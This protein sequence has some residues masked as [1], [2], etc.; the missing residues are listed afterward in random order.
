MYTVQLR[1]F[2][3]CTYSLF[4]VQQTTAFYSSTF[5]VFA[6]SQDLIPTPFINFDLSLHLTTSKWDFSLLLSESGPEETP[7]GIDHWDQLAVKSYSTVLVSIWRF[8]FQKVQ[9]GLTAV[10]EP[11]A[12]WMKMTRMFYLPSS[13]R[14]R[15]LAENEGWRGGWREGWRG[16]WIWSVHWTEHRRGERVFQ[17]TWMRLHCTPS[18][19]TVLQ[20]PEAPPSPPPSWILLALQTGLTPLPSLPHLTIFLS[21][22]LPH[23]PLS[24]Q[25]CLSWETALWNW[26]T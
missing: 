17:E 18:A 13:C 26:G 24:V 9:R 20:E 21:L 1:T 16:E 15:S 5:A 12:H 11:W 14:S 19:Q 3:K 2:S 8:I 25:S 22:S 6:Q 4:H 23:H 7:R 10:G